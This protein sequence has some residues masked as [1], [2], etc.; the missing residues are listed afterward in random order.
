[1]ADLV[2]ALHPVNIEDEMKRSY[3]DYAMSVI[4][5]RALPDARDG[6]KPAHRRVLYGMK[7]MGLSSTRGYRKCAKIVGEVM[8]NF[9]PHGDASIYDTLVRMAQDFNMRYP[10]VD[11]QGN[12]GSIDGDPPAAM[13]YTEARLKAIADDMMADLDKE[14]VDF[15][16]NY[17][18]TTEEPTVLPAPFPNLL[19]NGS[20]G[21]AVGMATN[22]PPHNLREVIDGCIWLIENSYFRHEG[23]AEAEAAESDAS[24]SSRSSAS[25]TRA[26]KLRNL[27]RLIPAPDFPTGGLIVGR[28]GAVQAYTTGRGSILMRAKSI[29]ETNKKGDKQSIIVT[30]IPY[31]VNKAKLIERIA[32]L[33]RDK[34]IDGIS[35]LRD[36]SDR[37]GMRIVIE[38]RRG[39]VPEVILNNLY[40]HTQLQLG[41]GIIMLAIVGGRPKVMTLLEL[42]ESFIDFR[43]EVVRRRTE[44]ELRKAEARYHVLEGLKIALD[45]LDA[46]IVLI[47]G[48]KTV[49]EA[50]EGLITQFGLSQLQSQAILDMQLQRLTGLERQK[51]LDELAELL[52]TIERLRA[53]LASERL[54]MQMI[55]DE[56]RQVRTKYGDDRRTE[57]IEAESGE[58]SIE[59]L[60]AEEDMAI[61]VSNTGYIKRTAISTYRNQRR[62]GKG[63]IG[64]RTR[65]EDFV[66]HLFVAS[67]HAYIMIF[68]DRGRAY[69][70]KVHEIPDVGPSGK[71]KSIANL[72]SM[73]EGEK[74]AALLAVKEFDEGS[75][76]V[77]GTRRGVVKK[78]ALSAFSNPRAGGIIAM[79][80]EEN[81]SVIAV[82]VTDGS[83][84]V[85]I[86]TRYGMAIRFHESDVRPM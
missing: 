34:T 82:Q 41:F 69:W 48:S 11:G 56:L 26:E 66:S 10:L 78:T 19:V 20:A 81:D 68:S 84:E 6:L 60:I 63:R 85:F 40:K 45:H 17:D 28:Q 55:V 23:A 49:P 16:P 21:I 2:P 25:L 7:T 29:L 83:G 35:D 38:L 70:L 73:E 79:G 46:V 32:D 71:G 4:I 61:T 52:K 42:I 64:M 67:T 1:M 36:E 27:I 12:F 77:M 9:H 50:R 5:G 37:E 53:I 59:D 75:F 76:V 43:R 3:M 72:V 31:Q 65:D 62:G 57:I 86:G 51:I 58:L 74:I 15:A 18:E 80:V 30:E 14:T 22:V 47:R 33:V 8:G 44:F 13:R 54:L 24:A 39:E